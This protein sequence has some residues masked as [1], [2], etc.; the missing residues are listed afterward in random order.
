M[1]L[2][3]AY[4]PVSLLLVQFFLLFSF[5]LPLPVS[6]TRF[7]DLESCLNSYLS[8]CLYEALVWLAS[9]FV[10]GSKPG[11]DQGPRRSGRQRA[12]LISTVLSSY[13]RVWNRF[14]LNDNDQTRER[15]RDRPFPSFDPDQTSRRFSTTI[16][17]VRLSS[18]PLPPW[19]SLRPI[20]GPSPLFFPGGRF[21]VDRSNRLK[22]L[23]PVTRYANIF[24]A[25]LHLT[26]EINDSRERE[27]GGGIVDEDRDVFSAAEKF[28]HGRDQ[29]ADLI[30]DFSW[31]TPSPS[32][33]PSPS[34]SSPFRG[35]VR[36]EEFDWR[37]VYSGKGDVD[38]V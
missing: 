2:S 38:R 19:I 36:S 8:A 18:P 16:A 32:P 21:V 30:C 31:S 27:G 23:A 34:P 4:G 29:R 28:R 3:S 26:A 1:P 12:A 20:S 9:T 7:R 10:Q 37:K 11:E 5:P 6:L 17:Y 33:F 14:F 15:E 13:Y 24:T 35:I 22:T 25:P